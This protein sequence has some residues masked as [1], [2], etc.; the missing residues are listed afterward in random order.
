MASPADNG[1]I[2]YAAETMTEQAADIYQLI[3]NVVENIDAQYEFWLTTTFAVVAAS[4]F[5]RKQ[6]NRA[7]RITIAALYLL[8]VGLVLL[9]LGHHVEQTVYLSGL[10]GNLGVDPPRT[11]STIALP[12]RILVLLLGS[13]AATLFVLRPSLSE[14]ETRSH[15]A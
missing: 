6:L 12:L 5:A 3:Q 8:S 2:R 11:Y 15:D 10:L 14:P 4:F 9:R 13:G 1:R 7:L